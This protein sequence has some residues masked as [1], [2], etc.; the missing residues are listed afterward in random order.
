[1]ANEMLAN[2][3]LLAVPSLGKGGLTGTRSGHFGQCDT[4]TLVRV[5]GGKVKDVQ[6]IDNP[7]HVEGGCLRP[8][9]L[10]ASNGV[11]DLVVA[12]MGGRPLMGF[13][14]AGINVHFENVT[15]HID[16]VT[17]MVISGDV[18]PMDDRFVCGGH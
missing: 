18:E 1:M 9:E 10:L 13:R 11:T 5:A 14:Q 7:P 17:S 16:R 12:G 6:V 3:M 4:F 15:P 8:V 2:E